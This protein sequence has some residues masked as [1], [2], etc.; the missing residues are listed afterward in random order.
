M[1]I[2]APSVS[3]C[4]R[5]SVEAKVP[6][7]FNAAWMAS[8][9]FSIDEPD[10]G[11]SICIVTVCFPRSI[12]FAGI[13]RLWVMIYYLPHDTLGFHRMQHQIAVTLQVRAMIDRVGLVTR[14]FDLLW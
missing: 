13:S 2:G 1:S 12:T 7:S 14:I 5:A 3:N 8:S 10:R 11:I 4:L 6:A 9:D